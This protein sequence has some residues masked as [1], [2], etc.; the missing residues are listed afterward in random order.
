MV[1]NQSMKK[2]NK[3]LLL[4]LGR[5]IATLAIL[6]AVGFAGM[7]ALAIIVCT[8]GGSLVT[9][10]PIAI[11]V[12]PIVVEILHLIWRRESP[13]EKAPGIVQEQ[14]PMS[15]N[16]IALVR[17]IDEAR[18]ANMTDDQIKSELTQKQWS[19]DDIDSAF[20]LSSKKN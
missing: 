4:F 15:K 12:L 6:G 16:D 5:L 17:Y 10:I 1:K 20:K 2:N 8:G 9:I 7:M 3:S 18:A 13:T 14:K 19:M 11:V